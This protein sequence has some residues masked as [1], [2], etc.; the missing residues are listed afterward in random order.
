MMG[1]ITTMQHVRC[2]KCGN[3]AAY[4]G[5]TKRGAEAIMRL[6]GWEKLAAKWYCPTCVRK[7]VK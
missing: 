4:E 1:K 6:E 3:T 5:T 7:A 2:G